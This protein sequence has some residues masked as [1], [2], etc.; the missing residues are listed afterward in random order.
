MRPCGAVLFRDME[1]S[2]RHLSGQKQP[3]L[4]QTPRLAKLLKP[5]G[6]QHFAQCVRGIDGP[7]D[8]YMRDMYA[9][10]GIFSIECLA[11]HTTTGHGRCMA[12]LPGIAPH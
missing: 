5:V 9:L 6:P 7:V 1:I 2:L 10:T 8:D 11:E 4:I 3:V 12:M